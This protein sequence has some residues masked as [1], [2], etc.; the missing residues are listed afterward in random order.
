MSLAVGAILNRRFRVLRTLGE[1]GMGSVYEV[2]DLAQ[3]GRTWALKLLLD[4]P[5]ASTEDRAWA[6]DRFKDEVKLLKRLHH[7]RIPTFEADFT[8]QTPCYFVMEFIPGETLEQRLERVKGPL[9]E[10]DVLQ[11]MIDICDVLAY[12][13]EQQPPIII[14]DLKP[15]NIIISPSI[16]SPAGEARLIDFG[17]ARTY[18]AGKA[19]NTD[20]VGTAVY[21]SPEHHGRG[22]TDARSDIYSLGVT[23]VH[24]LTGKE[25]VPMSI[26]QPGD[27]RGRT[28]QKPLFSEATERILIRATSL[29]PTQRYQS[30]REL[31]EALRASM[32]NA[33]ASAFASTAFAPASAAATQAPTRAAKAAPAPRAPVPTRPVFPSRA[34]PAAVAPASAAPARASAA[35]AP[36][37]AAIGG[38]V[39]PTCGFVN[40]P[41][42]RFCA[43]D[44]APLTV[45]AA[46]A[47]QTGK[48][49]HAGQRT[50]ATPHAAPTTQ[51]ITAASDAQVHARRASE[52]LSSARYVVAIKDAETAIAQGHATAEVYLTL[53]LAYH[54]VGRFAEAANAFEQ[55]ARL[56]PSAETLIKAGQEWQ[57]I[58]QLDQ[59]Q[60]ALTRARQLAPRDPEIP[61]L[62][63]VI[64]FEQGSLAQA[65]GELREALT[66]RPTDQPATQTLLALA[67]IAAA[68]KDWPGAIETLQ[69]AAQAAPQDGAAQLE[70]GRALLAARRLPE[71]VRALEQ[72]AKLAPDSAP[73]LTA[74]GMA[75]HGIGKRKQ[76]RDALQRALARDPHDSE[77]Q[78]LLQ[79][80]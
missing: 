51:I 63:G 59:A 80:V 19:S 27:L 48:V 14:R 17:I 16:H 18:K 50:H 76:A 29:V 47:Q 39:C 42:A 73:T 61:Y 54:Q 2:A 49:G 20:N 34:A 10:Y 32:R 30:A 55:S 1:G 43:R 33:P 8:D 65:E 23:M 64:C 67:R 7:P 25:P 31:R 79:S 53:G 70:L 13:H 40:R 28:P 78:T 44:G 9:P 52:S 3:P 71:A 77:A 57:A 66:L 35:A 36:V 38:S 37:G 5:N 62:L 56:R 11:W 21:A 41:S 69:R 4:D 74:L 26:Y 68:R 60:V 46:I 75:Y 24:L 45:G 22:Q 6:R 15:G 12:L 58:G 72:A